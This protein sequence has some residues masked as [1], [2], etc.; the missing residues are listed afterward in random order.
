MK[1]GTTFL[2]GLLKSH[3]LIY[4]SPEKELHFLSQYFGEIKLL[5]DDVRL[6]KA[7]DLIQSPRVKFTSIKEM[8]ARLQWLSDY[9]EPPTTISWYERL[10][11]KIRPSQYAA[12]FSNLT[13]TIPREGLRRIF[14]IMPNTWITYCV[15]DPVDRAFSH[16][17]FHMKVAGYKGLV[18]DLPESQVRSII[19]SRNILPQS[20]TEKHVANLLSVFGKEKFRIIRCELMWQEP[21]IV[22]DG[23]CDFLGI[24]PFALG[25][26]KQKAIN[27]GPT[28]E[29]SEQVL[30]L[31]AEEL[32]DEIAGT[33]RCLDTYADLVLDGSR[34]TSS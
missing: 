13:C 19:R 28:E 14:E 22:V 15:R 26:A 23:I 20:E 11:D 25:P 4:F 17:K 3:P 29:P 18:S 2:Y 8:K 21:Q 33:H 10:F 7:Q 27:V 24:S 12:D 16:L 9:L 1:A 32:H 5:S 34:D 31:I 30:S 6:R